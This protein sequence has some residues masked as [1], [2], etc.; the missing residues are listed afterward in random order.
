MVDRAAEADASVSMRQPVTSPVRRQVRSL[1]RLLLLLGV[2][3][4]CLGLYGVGV[5]LLTLAWPHTEAVILASRIDLAETTSTVP[6][7]DK[8]R[9]GRIE[10]R[11]TATFYVRYRY[12]V[13]GRNYEA[14]SVEP[15]AFGLQ[16]SATLRELGDAYR[17]GQ[18][19]TIAYDPRRPDRA[20]LRPGP[21]SPAVMLSLVGGALALAGL[22]LT[23]R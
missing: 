18:H 2:P 1:S 20:Y 8:Y 17:P 4:L 10:T 16:T 13:D 11:Q 21:N 22:R 15:A 3:L 19:V 6:G 23:R 9:G 5:G 14:D 12:R 7:T